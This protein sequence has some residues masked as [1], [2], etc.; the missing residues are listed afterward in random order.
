MK[1]CNLIIRNC[2]HLIPTSEKLSDK[3]DY[4]NIIEPN[5]TT[6]QKTVILPRT[7]ILQILSYHQLEPSPNVLLGNQRGI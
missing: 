2:C 3:H 7:D 1:K 4:E 5:E 6:S